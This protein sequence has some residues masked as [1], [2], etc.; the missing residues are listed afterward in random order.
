MRRLDKLES[1]SY[2]RIKQTSEGEEGEEDEITTINISNELEKAKNFLEEES[3][4]TYEMQHHLKFLKIF[5][6]D[7]VLAG[8]P[9]DRAIELFEE[10]FGQTP[11]QQIRA[12]KK[13]FEKPP[14]QL[15]KSDYESTYESTIESYLEGESLLEDD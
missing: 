3:L 11:E 12:I 8:I 13:V 15:D 4:I 6:D 9:R 7:M 1:I 2:S 10:D 14:S 5:K